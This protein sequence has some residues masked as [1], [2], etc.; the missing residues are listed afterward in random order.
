MI[1]QDSI[2]GDL[3]LRLN[4]EYPSLEEC[5][6]QGYESACEESVEENNPYQ[7]GSKEFKFWQDGWW[8]G[9]YQEE[10]VFDI[11]AFIT[12]ESSLHA[13]KV[14]DEE[15]LAAN[16]ESFLHL[17]HGFMVNF[18]KITGIIAASAVVGYQVL[19]LVA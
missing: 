9:F 15:G 1:K 18:F 10:P 6:A 7:K 5:Y 2:L 14:H 3:K 8:A 19:E 17:P 16:E 13:E 12:K 4:I 11:S